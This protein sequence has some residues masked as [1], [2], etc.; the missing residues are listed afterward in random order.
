MLE[1]II[2]DRLF[3]TLNNR[4]LIVYIN[5]AHFLSNVILR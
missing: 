1:L 4:Y 5:D 2:E 3:K